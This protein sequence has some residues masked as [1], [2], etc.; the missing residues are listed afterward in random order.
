MD[1][2]ILFVDDDSNILAAHRRQFHKKFKVIAVDSGNKGID[3]LE[4]QGPIAVV[5]SD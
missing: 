1:E 3:V 4:E 5:V 2:K